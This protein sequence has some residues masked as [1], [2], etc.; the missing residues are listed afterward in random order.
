ML[1]EAFHT[2]ARAQSLVDEK[3]RTAVWSQLAQ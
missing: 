1:K 2:V 3:F